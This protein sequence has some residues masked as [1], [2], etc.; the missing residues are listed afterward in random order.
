MDDKKKKY[1]IPEAD[2]VNYNSEDIVTLS[3]GALAGMED[4]EELL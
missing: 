1:V 3:E 4:G 2:V